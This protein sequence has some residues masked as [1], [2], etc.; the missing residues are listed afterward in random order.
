MTE[1]IRRTKEMLIWQVRLN[2]LIRMGIA[3]GLSENQMA[4]AVLLYQKKYGG[5]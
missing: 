3:M 4:V 5:L 2:Q 1:I